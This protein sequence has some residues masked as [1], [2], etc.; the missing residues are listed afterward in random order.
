MIFARP[1]ACSGLDTTAQARLSFAICNFMKVFIT[2]GAGFIG[3]NFAADHLKQGDHVTIFDNL[4]RPRTQ[5][6]LDWLKGQ[7][8]SGQLNFVKGDVRDPEAIKQAVSDARPELIAHLAAQ[9]AVTTSVTNPR[10]D[11][12]INAFGTFNVLEA[13]RAQPNPPALIYAS[14]NKVYGGMEDIKVELRGDRYEYADYPEGIDEHQP[15]DLHSPYGCSKGTGDQYVRDYARIYGLRTVVFRQS[16]IYGT[17]QFGVEDQ[18]WLAHFIIAVVMGRQ[19]SIYGDGKQVR[20]MLHVSD[21]VRAYNAAAQNMDSVAGQIFNVGGG[22]K[23]TISIWTETAP[24]LERLNGKPIP[25]KQGD[26]RPGDQLVC[27]MNS[28][29][30]KAMLG[31]EPQVGLD[32]GITQLWNWVSSNKNLFK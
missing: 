8:A 17:R 31:W 2:G 29:K 19:L 15:L 6:N 22:A 9:V 14:T 27:V 10:E 32:E 24:I 5:F 20:D 25:V 23:N 16:T 21:L 12:D 7:A 11:F 13:A 26:W 18:G 3:C 30:A 28:A 1:P 4:S